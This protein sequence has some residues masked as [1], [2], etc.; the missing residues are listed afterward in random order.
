MCVR[1]RVGA[2]VC[3]CVRA[4]VLAFMFF[5]WGGGEGVV[6]GGAD[7]GVS[8][9]RLAARPGGVLEIRNSRSYRNG[10]SCTFLSVHGVV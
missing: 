7:E 5:Y 2:R 1:A 8:D 10:F 4:C 3:A 9:Q 6:V